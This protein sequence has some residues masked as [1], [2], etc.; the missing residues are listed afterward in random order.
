MRQ[1][2]G[3]SEGYSMGL[4]LRL[5]LSFPPNSVGVADSVRKEREARLGALHFLY[6]LI[7]SSTEPNDGLNFFSAQLMA[8]GRG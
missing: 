4:T 3:V 1:Y 5:G 8:P 7:T 2:A 6:G